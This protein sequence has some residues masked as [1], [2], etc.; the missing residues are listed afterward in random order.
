MFITAPCHVSGNLFKRLRVLDELN[1]CG[2][3]ITAFDVVAY[4]SCR[5]SLDDYC[6]LQTQRGHS[7]F[8]INA[9]I[10]NGG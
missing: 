10:G 5:A 2:L 7:D 1:C 3:I 6:T 4:F 8:S 9:H